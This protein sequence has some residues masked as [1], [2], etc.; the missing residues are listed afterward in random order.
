[1]RGVAIDLKDRGITRAGEA[2]MQLE[3]R[4]TIGPI[5]LVP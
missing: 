5:V 4:T 3:S 2:H 1:M